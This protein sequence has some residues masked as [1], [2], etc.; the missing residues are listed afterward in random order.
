MRLGFNIKSKEKRNKKV[1]KILSVVLCAVLL[2]G[3]FGTSVFAD[4]ASDKSASVSVTIADGKG[5]LVLTQKAVTVKD[6]DAD[7][8]LTVSDALYA[9]HEAAFE[10][11]AAAGYSATSSTSGLFLTKLWGEENGGS[12][13]YAVNHKLANSL[14]DPV[15]DGDIIDAFVYTDLVTWSDK[16]CYFDIDRASVEF[17]SKL[18]LTLMSVGF[19]PVTYAPVTAPVAGANITLNGKNT[20]L[21]TDSDGRTELLLDGVG[22]N[23]ISAKSDDAVLVPPVCIINVATDITTEVYVTI[24]DADGKLALVREKVTVKDIDFDGAITV[25]D[26][27]YAAHEAAY[28]GGAAAGY[29]AVQSEWGL[30]LAKLWGAENG[31]SYG[32]YVNNKASWSLA[33]PV[34]D[35]DLVSA[36]VY[37]D[38]KAWSDTYCYFDSIDASVMPGQEFTVTLLSAGYDADGTPITVPVE[39]AEILIDG[40]PTGVFTDAEGRATLSYDIEGRFL[41]S[42]KSASAVLVPPALEL[43]VIKD[44]ITL[45]TADAS[46]TNDDVVSAPPTGDA[47]IEV[48]ILAASAVILAAA[49]VFTNRK[50]INE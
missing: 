8:A 31:G 3:L 22:V 19:D 50:K 34:K 44:K 1:K 48:V 13:G 39:G 5:Q 25:N 37:T 6:F 49:V 4:S 33:D 41:L 16:Y 35:G 43:T 7:G 12:Y 11:G 20:G 36:F 45:P 30:S 15:K 14:A 40:E 17:D 18:V 21:V 29:A 38:L 26:A 47:A 2:T 32:Y 23:V 46:D 9:A 28:E 24:A 42:A 27:L 10:G